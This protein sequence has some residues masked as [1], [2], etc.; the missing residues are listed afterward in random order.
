MRP[1]LTETDLSWAAHTA[2]LADK[3]TLAQALRESRAQT[4][5][6]LQ[7]YAQALDPSLTVPYSPELNPPLWEAGHIAWFADWW[8]ARN[9]HRGLGL[10]A[11]PLVPRLPAR[12]SARGVD[13]DALYDSSRVPHQTRWH[14]LLPDLASVQDDL[15]ASLEDTLAA[16]QTAQEDDQGLYLFR[17]AVLH[18]DMHAEAAAYMAQ[19]LGLDVPD[20]VWPKAAMPASPA[21]LAGSQRHIP[22]Q[23]VQLAWQGPGFAFDNEC[24]DARVAV[25]AFTVDAQAVRWAA[26]LPFVEEGG[27]DD[28]RCWSPAGWTWCQAQ[29]RPGPRYLQRRA[30]G[31]FVQHGSRLSPLD[32]TAPAS[33][34]TMYEAQAWCTWAG[35]RL[36]TEA[37]WVAAARAQAP[38]SWGEVWEWTSSPF[39]PFTGFMPHP[40][41]DYSQPWFDGRPVLKGASRL[42]HPRMRHPLYRNYF[43][44]ERND[45]VSGLRSVAL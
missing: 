38:I 16:L 37:E 34:L 28:P 33:H 43:T 1:I 7:V 20:E 32:E 26:Y 12:L 24:L 10:H 15:L 39:A 2:R 6:G 40:Y 8:I 3:A 27:Y 42:T 11:D 14:L 29:R 30:E 23:A 17:L 44:P 41:Q 22:A 5:R 21:S 31:W 18:E 35:R 19:T 4:L 25:D 36:P 9:P 13:V 45:I